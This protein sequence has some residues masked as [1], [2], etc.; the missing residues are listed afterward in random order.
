MA[1]CRRYTALG[2]QEWHPC[3]DRDIERWKC[4]SE[5]SRLVHINGMQSAFSRDD[6]K[7]CSILVPPSVCQNKTKWPEV[8]ALETRITSPSLQLTIKLEQGACRDQHCQHFQH[9]QH[10][11]HYQHVPK[12]MW[13]PSPCPSPPFAS[14]L[15]HISC[16]GEALTLNWFQINMYRQYFYFVWECQP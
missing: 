15:L 14:P 8:G 12:A 3:S 2:E 11:Q 5:T 6:R 4:R 10:Y 1:T 9:Y 7:E 13:P 16:T